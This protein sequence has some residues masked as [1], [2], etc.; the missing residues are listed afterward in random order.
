[1]TKGQGEWIRRYRAAPGAAVQVVCLPHAG[2]SANYFRPMAQAL[3]P[4]AEVLAVQY[5]GRMDRV[6]EPYAG[7]FEELT[8][9]ALAA[10]RREVDRPVVLF[11]HSMGALLAFQVARRLE[12]EGAVPLAL[13]ASGARPPGA[14]LPRHT[15][16]ETDEEMITDLATLGGTDER[17]LDNEDMRELVLSALRADY[18][19]LASHR[20]DNSTVA[21]PV[22][23]LT[24]DSDPVVSI[25]DARAWASHTAGRFDLHVFAGR[26]FYLDDHWAAVSAVVTRHLGTHERTRTG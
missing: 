10:V 26:H 11:G 9:C 16:A 15:R 23:A 13:F 20:R 8:E 7:D 21:C 18:R 3:A 12:A 19:I 5:P 24:G 1:M 6:N 2:G 17:L 4:T 22:V 25:D 14:A